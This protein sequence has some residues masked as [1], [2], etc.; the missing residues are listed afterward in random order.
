M[1]IEFVNDDERCPYDPI[2]GKHCENVGV[3]AIKRATW[4]LTRALVCED[5]LWRYLSNGWE[6]VVE[7]LTAEG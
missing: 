3:I 4:N 2:N 5:H 7:V 1:T 6:R